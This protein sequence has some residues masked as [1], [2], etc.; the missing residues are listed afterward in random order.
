MV[1]VINAAQ[2]GFS[3][4]MTEEDA[5]NF[6]ANNNDKLLLHLATVDQKGE[7]TVAPTGYYFDADTNKIYIATHKSSRKVRDLRRIKNIISYCVDDPI[8]P[9]KGVR[10]KGKVKIHGEE[11]DIDHNIT[12]GKKLAMGRIESLEDPMAK[13]LL[14]EIEKGSEIILEITPSYYS[15]WDYSKTR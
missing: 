5:E 6:L 15:T 9:Y 11:E 3:A 1:K 10:G 13:W 7:P 4:P 12:I 8:S 14:G 2:P